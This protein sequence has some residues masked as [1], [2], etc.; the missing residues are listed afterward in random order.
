MSLTSVVS[1]YGPF[2]VPVAL[3][4]RNS[5]AAT[6]SA[7]WRSR[8]P[9]VKYVSLICVRKKGRAVG[10]LDR[11]HRFWIH[12]RSG[13]GALKFRHAPPTAG[14]GSEYRLDRQTVLNNDAK[15]VVQGLH[16]QHVTAVQRQRFDPLS[17]AINHQNGE[18]GAQCISAGAEPHGIGLPMK[19]G[20]LALRRRGAP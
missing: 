2:S 15:R 12:G 13:R 17:R 16:R 1:S 3:P 4:A 19:G 14:A 6:P 9:A 11:P 10:F 18:H 5:A 7:C 20:V 8:R